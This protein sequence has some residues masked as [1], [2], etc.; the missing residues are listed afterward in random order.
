MYQK[1]EGGNSSETESTATFYERLSFV[2]KFSN[3]FIPR[4]KRFGIESPTK[5]TPPKVWVNKL[6]FK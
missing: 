3:S 6:N 5:T 2:L 4:T 1:Y